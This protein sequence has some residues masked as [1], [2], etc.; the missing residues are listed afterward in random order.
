MKN[1]LITGVAGMIGSTLLKKL[2]ERKNINIIGLDNFTLGK[3][4]YIK[5]FL[6]YKNF[7]FFNINVSKKL[8][9]IELI[10]LLKKRKLSEIWLLAANSDIAA[11]V[12][13]SDVDFKNTYLTTYNILNDCYKFIDKNTKILFA[14]SSAIY[15]TVK[16]VISENTA[17]LKP[18][19]NYGSMK[20]ACESFI[21]SYSY[22]H[23]LKSFIF[24]F[25]NVVGTN[26]T[27]GVIYDLSRKIIA[28]KKYLNVLGNGHQCKPY[29]DVNE[30]ID[31]MIFLKEKKNNQLINFYN[32]GS[33]DKGVKVKEIVE[34]LV[35]KFNYNKRVK[36]QKQKFGWP[37][38]VLTYK[39]S[40]KNMKKAGFKF[41]LSSKE[42]LEK[43][44]NSL[45]KNLLK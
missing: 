13:N 26:L 11:G 10:K 21:S 20:A 37:G 38:D 18:E 28:N 9:N 5:Q 34:M 2:L 17:P 40:T 35:K 14:S 19:S 3:K 42:A 15:G 6:K 41:K 1:I 4:K 44:I 12:K 43:T 25:P 33:N 36:F 30:I 16:K 31:C 24:R 27:H 29:S 45:S 32:I 22:K 8:K 23:N 7:K 39:Y